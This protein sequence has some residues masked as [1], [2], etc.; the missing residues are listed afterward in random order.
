MT[1]FQEEASYALSFIVQNEKSSWIKTIFLLVDF[2]L[3]T[4]SKLKEVT[5]Q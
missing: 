4:I 2:C 1:E 3:P 5:L